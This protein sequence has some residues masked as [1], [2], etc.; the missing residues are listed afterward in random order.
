ML[1]D[2]YYE[3]VLSAKFHNE[4]TISPSGLVYNPSLQMKIPPIADPNDSQLANMPG[5]APP[6]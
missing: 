5:L 6:M 2:N 3:P 4:L 1:D